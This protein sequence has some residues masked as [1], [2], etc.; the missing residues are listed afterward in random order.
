MKNTI[1]AIF[2][3]LLVGCEAHTSVEEMSKVSEL[4]I[5]YSGMKSVTAVAWPDNDI[6]WKVVCNDGTKLSLGP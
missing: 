4:C 5:P 3:I 6:S 1:F 2:F